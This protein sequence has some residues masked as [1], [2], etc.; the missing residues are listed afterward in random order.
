MSRKRRKRQNIFD[1]AF[2][3]RQIR[4][5]T[6]KKSRRNVSKNSGASGRSWNGS[7]PEG[8]SCPSPARATS[9]RPSGPI[10]CPTWRALSSESRR[11]FGSMLKVEKSFWS[12]LK[13][14]EMSP[15]FTW[16]KWTRGSKIGNKVSRTIWMDPKLSNSFQGW[17]SRR[18]DPAVFYNR[19]KKCQVQ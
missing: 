5:S 18:G 3:V 13:S 19:P 15:N 2:D 12:V 17:L 4:R 7:D 9:C 1:S 14:L 10:S 11:G 8:C 6:V 16:G